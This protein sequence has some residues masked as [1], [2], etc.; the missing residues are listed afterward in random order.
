MDMAFVQIKHQPIKSGSIAGAP[1]VSGN[2]TSGPKPCLNPE[3][4][5]TIISEIVRDGCSYHYITFHLTKLANEMNTL[6][7]AGEAGKNS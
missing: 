3:S 4:S 6:N 5:F 2:D 1:W 7:T